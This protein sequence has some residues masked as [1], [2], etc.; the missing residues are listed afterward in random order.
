[1]PYAVETK[2][3]GLRGVADPLE[4]KVVLQ[5][6]M[7]CEVKTVEALQVLRFDRRPL[8][9]QVAGELVDQ[10]RGCCRCQPAHSFHLEGAAQ[11]HVL[12]GIGNLDQ[13][14]ARA[15]LRD[16]VDQA[17]G[18]QPVHRF[19]D[20][21]A[22]HAHAGRNGLLVQELARLQVELDNCFAQ[23]GMNTG[24]GALGHRS[25]RTQEIIGDGSHWHAN[26]LAIFKGRASPAVKKRAF[27]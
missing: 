1:M 7:E 19:A 20:G 8:V 23:R 18:G 26:M 15:A 3:R 25:A 4:A 24:R 2:P 17:L 13:C 11:E 6:G 9:A 12:A 14:D 5:Q 10:L 22:R 27:R 21:E 16:D